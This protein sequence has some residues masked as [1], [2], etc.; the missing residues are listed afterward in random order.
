M[1]AGDV[2]HARWRCCCRCAAAAGAAGARR[3]GAPP[4]VL[5]FF[6]WGKPE[7]GGDA[8]ATLDAVAAD[9]R[10]APARGC[11]VDGA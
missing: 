2:V 6:D 9:Y 1:T 3:A 4:P 8:A 7:I 11:V 10:A 5:V